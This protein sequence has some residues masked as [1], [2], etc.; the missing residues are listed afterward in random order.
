V[1]A[2]WKLSINSN[3]LQISISGMPVVEASLQHHRS[4]INTNVSGSKSE[5]IVQCFVCHS[6][7][8]FR[9]DLLHSIESVCTVL[10]RT[11]VLLN[12]EPILARNLSV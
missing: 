4:F 7:A 1:S 12:F 5:T 2:S 3:L 11:Y 10:S 6:I 8:V 9:C